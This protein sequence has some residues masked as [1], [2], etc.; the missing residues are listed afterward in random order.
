MSGLKGKMGKRVTKIG[1]RLERARHEPMAFFLSAVMLYLRLLVGED[2][3]IPY[4]EAC[5]GCRERHEPV[6]AE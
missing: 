5:G 3:A 1:G 2:E 6:E 4:R